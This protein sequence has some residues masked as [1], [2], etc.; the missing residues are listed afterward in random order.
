MTPACPARGAPSSSESCFHQESRA[1]GQP[2][3]KDL[4]SRFR[5]PKPSYCGRC[6]P[7]LAK[8]K[9]P[10]PLKSA[11][12]RPQMAFSFLPALP[13]QAASRKQSWRK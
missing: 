10:P 9:S 11:K 4:V 5:S 1:L 2:T 8:I 6:L 12:K 3:A 7:K 13:L